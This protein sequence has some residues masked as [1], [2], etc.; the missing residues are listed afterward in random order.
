MGQDQQQNL[1][2]TNTTPVIAR[3]PD[4]MTRRA[5][6]LT[7]VVAISAGT[8]GVAP[9]LSRLPS[10]RTA[11][12]CLAAGSK[13]IPFASG[14]WPCNRPAGGST[15]AHAPLHTCCHRPP[16]PAPDHLVARASA[17]PAAVRF[18]T[19]PAPCPC[20]PEFPDCCTPPRV[21]TQGNP[22]SHPVPTGCPGPARSWQSS[23]SCI[24]GTAESG[25]VPRYRAL[26]SVLRVNYLPG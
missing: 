19:A 14:R 2:G 26:N 12:G 4:R 20:T 17:W 11:R 21:A 18:L 6:P 15:G 22:A 13:S 3:S 8:A 25:E 9:M 10:A 1:P 5:R 7:R 24:I 23:N 16:L